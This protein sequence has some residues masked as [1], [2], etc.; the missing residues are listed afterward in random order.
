[1][2]RRGSRRAKPVPSLTGLGSSLLAYPALTCGANECCRWCDS[3]RLFCG[4]FVFLFFRHQIYRVAAD[5]EGLFG[6]ACGLE[7]YAGRSSLPDWSGAGGVDRGTFYFFVDDVVPFNRFLQNGLAAVDL[8]YDRVNFLVVIRDSA[9]RGIVAVP[10]DGGVE[11]VELGK[12]DEG[13]VAG[14]TVDQEPSSALPFPVGR[15][16]GLL[17]KAVVEAEDAADYEERDRLRR[18]R[19]QV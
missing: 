3:V 5:G 11:D 18:E 15:G 14:C 7:G 4:F 1:M 2:R 8:G 16:R 9:V 13:D 12:I 17:R 10:A 19:G 6:C